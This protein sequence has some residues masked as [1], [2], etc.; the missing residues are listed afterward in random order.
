MLLSNSYRGIAHFSWKQKNDCYPQAFFLKIPRQSYCE[1]T[2]ST[3]DSTIHLRLHV[4][5]IL[6]INYETY[7]LCSSHV[8]CKSHTITSYL[9]WRHTR[10]RSNCYCSPDRLA[11]CYY[12]Y[13]IAL[14]YYII[15]CNLNMLQLGGSSH[16]LLKCILKIIKWSAINDAR[17]RKICKDL[18]LYPL[19][20]DGSKKVMEHWQSHESFDCSDDSMEE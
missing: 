15:A 20:K 17:G 19:M 2:F 14:L 6:C 12:N 10:Y 7:L 5:K 18:V 4:W 16:Y 3:K 13:F 8:S 1:L 11:Y 9:I